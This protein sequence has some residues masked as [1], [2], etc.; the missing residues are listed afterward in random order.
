MGPMS[1]V[2]GEQLAHA[3]ARVSLVLGEA[4]APTDGRVAQRFISCAQVQAREHPVYV[5]RGAQRFDRLQ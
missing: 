5:C 4:N 2:G 1:D 3:Q